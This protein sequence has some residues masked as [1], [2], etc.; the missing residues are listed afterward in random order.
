MK[1]EILPFF[2]RVWKGLCTGILIFFILGG[3][4]SCFGVNADISLNQDNSGTINLEYRISHA[5]D[6]LGRMEGNEGRPPIPVGRI[7]LERT[8]DRIPGMRLLSYNS[9]EDAR[10]RIIRARLHFSHIDALISFL[11]AAG[12]KAVFTGGDVQG[13]T[14]VLSQG[15]RQRNLELDT[16]ISQITQGYRVNISMSFPRE[17]TVA[18]EGPVESEIINLVSR[19]R[20]VSCSLPLGTVLSAEN[21]VSL[22]FRW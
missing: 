12:E 6:S 8:V 18:V 22:E 4:T 15:R 17:G 3:M 2:L 19:G 1:P 21:E 5:L 16:L 14:L 11:D 9:R 7:D 13:L 20:R 10:D